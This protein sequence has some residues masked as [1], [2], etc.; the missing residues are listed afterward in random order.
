MSLAAAK[1][2]R[3]NKAANGEKLSPAEANAM[4]E[5]SATATLREITGDAGA[6]A[7]VRNGALVLSHHGVAKD[8]QHAQVECPNCHERFVVSEQDA[9]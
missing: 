8:V 9:E 5:A 3:F 2:E 4:Y 7:H 1:A 6:R